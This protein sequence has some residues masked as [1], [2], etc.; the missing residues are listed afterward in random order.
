[1]MGLLSTLFLG[2]LE[3]SGIYSLQFNQMSFKFLQKIVD[4][5][6]KIQSI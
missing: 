2:I 3:L 6:Q 4:A 5:F 1:M